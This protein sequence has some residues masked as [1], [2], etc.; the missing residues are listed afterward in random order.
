MHYYLP[1]FDNK[2]LTDTGPKYATQ[3]EKGEWIGCVWWQ[4]L[5]HIPVLLNTS[6]IEP[7]EIH[8]RQWRLAGHIKSVV[9][10]PIR[11]IEQDLQ[12]GEIHPTAAAHTTALAQKCG[13]RDIATAEKIRA[14]LN[15]VLIYE[16]VERGV[17]AIDFVED[18]ADELVESRA[19]EFWR[20]R[21]CWTVRPLL[22]HAKYSV[23][24]RNDCI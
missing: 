4:R 8:Q 6:P 7:P 12:D 1:H 17:D 9:N 24:E 10:H 13:F 2:V 16:I 5:D 18:L 19:L 23:H 20:C 14:V 15:I 11:T 21:T 3:S 22:Y